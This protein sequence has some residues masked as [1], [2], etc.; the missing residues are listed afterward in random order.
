MARQQGRQPT[1]RGASEVG[2]DHQ[3]SQRAVDQPLHVGRCSQALGGGEEA[4]AQVD[5]IGTGRNGAGQA[6]A[7]TD[8]AARGQ[9]AATKRR[10]AA[11]DSGA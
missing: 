6:S 1:G 4:G 7:V 10:L 9:Q 11:R 2:T 8:A 5:A 3:V